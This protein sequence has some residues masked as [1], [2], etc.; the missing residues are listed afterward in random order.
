MRRGSFTRERSFLPISIPECPLQH[1]GRDHVV[2][3]I[4]NLEFAVCK[5]PAELAPE[6]STPLSIDFKVPIPDED[7]RQAVSEIVS[8]VLGR[9]L[10]KVGST[11]FDQTGHAI[12]QE[13]VNPWGKGL[14]GLC[15]E[16]DMPPVPIE[17]P[18][19]DAERLLC[20]LV[21]KY[22]E[23]RT[24]LELSDA[25][26]TYWV[27]IESPLSADLVHYAAAVE[28]LKNSWF[29]STRTKS[30][31]VYL[32]KE[33]YERLSCKTIDS[34]RG[35]VP[36]AVL[37]R[38]TGAYRMG[39]AEQLRAFFDEIELPVGSNEEQ[40]M[41]ARHGSAHG[42]LSTEADVEELVRHAN[43]YRALFERTF[44][45]LLGYEGNYIDR[46][47]IGHPSRPLREPAGGYST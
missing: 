38:I 40:A 12:E 39:N 13:A 31:G 2:V 29:R 1:N 22:L 44:L 26:W 34:L 43:G 14:K 18:S 11:L 25:L 17:M 33:D 10:M 28:A 32:P 46:S 45:R 3:D 30:K 6:W 16:W 42:G 41:K 23:N 36:Q 5:V 35:Q 19:T 15:E 37:N 4:D 24:S 9:R 8:F 47:T 20:E 7:V 27:A 21:P